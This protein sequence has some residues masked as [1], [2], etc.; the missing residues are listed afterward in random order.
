[1]D[2]RGQISVEFV[3]LVAI[4]LAIVLVFA[5]IIG[6]QNEQNSVATAIRLGAVNATAEMSILNRT[7][8]PV[9][10]NEVIMNG[11]GNITMLIH[12][13]YSSSQIQNT[14]LTGVAI[15][16]NSQGYT[17]QKNMVSNIIQN[18]TVNT[19]RHSYFIRIA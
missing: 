16:L 2:G 11:S 7:M 13:S 4:V 6:D 19:S 10:V 12:L 9:R 17:V 14:T 1:M 15:S 8:E 18:L 5:G 3:L